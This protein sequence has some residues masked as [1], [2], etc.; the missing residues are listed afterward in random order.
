MTPVKIKNFWPKM[1][2]IFQF[3]EDNPETW[4]RDELVHLKHSA[5]NMAKHSKILNGVMHNP[6]QPINLRIAFHIRDEILPI[7]RYFIEG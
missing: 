3:M 5:A 7:L 1:E 2:E 6:K 4:E